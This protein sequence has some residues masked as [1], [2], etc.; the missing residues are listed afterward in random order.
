MSWVGYF[1]LFFY[2]E[3]MKKAHIDVYISVSVSHEN[4]K[5]RPEIVASILPQKDRTLLGIPRK[6]EKCRQ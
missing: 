3:D 2:H 4:K 6:R 1:V 5:I